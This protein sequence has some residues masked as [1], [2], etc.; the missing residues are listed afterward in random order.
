MLI[1]VFLFT[2]FAKVFRKLSNITDTKGLA[3]GEGLLLHRT[4]MPLHVLFSQQLID[5]IFGIAYQHCGWYILMQV[6][7][8]MVAIYVVE[9]GP[10]IAGIG[11]I[12]TVISNIATLVKFHCLISFINVCIYYFTDTYDIRAN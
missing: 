8:A 5:R 3:V 12:G 9:H 2:A 1:K 11:N 4:A 6:L 7:Q 10:Q